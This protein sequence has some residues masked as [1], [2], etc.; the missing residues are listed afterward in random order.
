M[1][2]SWIYATLKLYLLDVIKH[3][4]TNTV[5]PSPAAGALPVFLKP[6]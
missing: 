5:S 2:I 6:I 4:Q 3:F 1:F